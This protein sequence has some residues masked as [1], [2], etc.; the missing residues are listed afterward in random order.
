[1]SFGIIF[2]VQKQS[3]RN[4]ID[5]I[6][7]YLPLLVSFD[8]MISGSQSMAPGPAVSA[9]LGNLTETQIP[10]PHPTPTELEILSGGIR[11]PVLQQTLQHVLLHSQ[12]GEHRNGH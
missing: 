10:W 4:C 8:G 2:L 12:V 9:S 11:Q 7:F 3:L 1:M 6:P 5:L